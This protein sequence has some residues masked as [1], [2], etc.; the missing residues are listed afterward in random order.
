MANN[1]EQTKKNIDQLAK[2]TKQFA[3]IF[4]GASDQVTSGIYEM[5]IEFSELRAKMNALKDESEQLRKSMELDLRSG[6]TANIDK[7]LAK[8]QQLDKETSSLSTAVIAH[9]KAMNSAFSDEFDSSWAESLKSQMNDMSSFMKRT[10]GGF[11]KLGEIRPDLDNFSKEFIK[12]N[13]IIENEMGRLTRYGKVRSEIEK[14]L[15]F[16]VTRVDIADELTQKQADLSK[17]KDIKNNLYGG[18]DKKEINQ[19]L[20]AYEEVLE[21]AKKLKNKEGKLLY[22]DVKY[23]D[24]NQF[25]TIA[26]NEEITKL[27]AD[28]FS[29]AS[30]GASYAELATEI[31]NLETAIKALDSSVGTKVTGYVDLFNRAYNL[32]QS[33]NVNKGLIEEVAFNP[34]SQLSEDKMKSISATDFNKYVKEFDALVDWEFG[35]R[36]EAIKEETAA[37]DDL[38]I[39]LKEILDLDTTI[40]KEKKEELINDSK[41]N[42]LIEQR[43]KTLD[44]V[45]ND[46][47]AIGRKTINVNSTPIKVTDARGRVELE[48][49]K[50]GI[51]EAVDA[52]KLLKKEQEE[53]SAKLST[54]GGLLDTSRIDYS[55]TAMDQVKGVLES[56]Y[57]VNIN[58]GTEAFEQLKLIESTFKSMIDG[59]KN[60]KIAVVDDTDVADAVKIKVLE[61]AITKEKREQESKAKAIANY[62]QNKVKYLELQRQSAEKQKAI[63]AYEYMMQREL[64]AAESASEKKDITNKYTGRRVYNAKA[65]SYTGSI[66]LITNVKSNKAEIDKEEVEEE[67]AESSAKAEKEN[68]EEKEKL[69][70]FHGH[71]DRRIYHVCRQRGYRRI[72]EDPWKG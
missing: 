41:I 36:V 57:R 24:V 40:S 27:G 26:I 69:T 29:K 58:A 33:A 6:N 13:D 16:T 19:W 22:K 3:D 49:Y 45:K 67:Q 11:R 72:P 32:M 52:V 38:K 12:Q 4:N 10:E 28:K 34:F 35:G 30:K 8:F 9:I 61:E 59:Y 31:K 54:K 37:T 63:M 7:Y 18:V 62:E 71:R 56:G 1:I 51:A 68:V 25:D 60:T 53:T 47:E 21:K 17:Y 14:S 64:S 39:K 65:Q 20:K 66:G 43:K 46:L 5:G 50:I 23:G 44:Y 42:V 55:S 48:S 2:S 15:G 70:C